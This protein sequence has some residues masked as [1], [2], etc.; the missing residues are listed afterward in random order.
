[1]ILDKLGKEFNISTLMKIVFKPEYSNM[2]NKITNI[3]TPV[4]NDILITL[5]D[6]KYHTETE[7][8]RLTKKKHQYLGPITLTTMIESLNSHTKNSYLVKK[9]VNGR[10]YYKI[11]DNYVGL[12]KAAFTKFRFANI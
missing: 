8:I 5:L 1:M 3:N 9:I 10:V 4:K 6:G 11:S 2:F 7:I 12:T